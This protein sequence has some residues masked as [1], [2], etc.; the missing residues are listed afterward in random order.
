MGINL[1]EL[2]FVGLTD[3]RRARFFSYSRNL[4]LGLEHCNKPTLAP[5]GFECQSIFHNMAA[6]RPKENPA[7]DPGF[8]REESANELARASFTA[9]LST[10]LLP[11]V[12]CPPVACSQKH[13]SRHYSLMRSRPT[14][15]GSSGMSGDS[16][17]TRQLDAGGQSE[18]A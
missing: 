10:G 6:D 1:L 18:H 7:F 9:L 3:Q 13:T 12:L 14:T 17:T 4:L 16:T 2:L 15:S 8:R 11:S 5:C